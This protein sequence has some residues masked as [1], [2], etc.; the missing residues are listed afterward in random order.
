[1]QLGL[2]VCRLHSIR[3]CC[4]PPL[5]PP[6]HPLQLRYSTDAT[7]TFNSSNLQVSFMLDGYTITWIPQPATQQAISGNLYGT[8]RVGGTFVARACGGHRRPFQRV[9]LTSSPSIC[10][11]FPPLPP[12]LPLPPSLLSQTL[13]GNNGTN[14]PL[15][16]YK[17]SR[18][19]LHC[20]LGW[21]GQGCGVVC[22]GW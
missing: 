4:T 21:E 20:T 18:A 13:D 22:C 7:T 11:P 16:C 9:V 1:M 3:L 10:P 6:D 14:E 8:F 15:N 2:C 5:P 12:L 17:N 19:D